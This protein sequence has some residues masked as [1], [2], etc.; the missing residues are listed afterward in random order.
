MAIFIVRGPDA[1][2]ALLQPA[3]PLPRPVMN[4]LVHRALDVGISVAQ[5]NCRSE[6]ELLDAL[7]A[8][9]HNP[10]DVILLAPA[11]CVHSLRL[12]RLLARLRNT[13]VEVHDDASDAPPSCLPERLGRRLGIA[14]GYCA[15]SYVLA[16]ELALEHL[17][18]SDVGD[19]VHVGT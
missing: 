12:Q 13:Y 9:N 6:Q 2:D 16:M 1:C 5:R 11:A 7:C 10:D 17:C 4:A 8:A 19:R 14:Q 18:C 3:V 15:Q